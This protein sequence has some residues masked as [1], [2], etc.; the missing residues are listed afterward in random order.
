[1]KVLFKNTPEI[2]DDINK[3]ILYILDQKI[4][5]QIQKQA[6]MHI[7]SII[8]RNWILEKIIEK[9]NKWYY[10]AK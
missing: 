5:L 4:E 7:N 9:E 8:T 6:T 10:E 3:T 1:M 2:E